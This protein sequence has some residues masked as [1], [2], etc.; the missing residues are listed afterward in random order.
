MYVHIL[1][2]LV[3]AISDNKNLLQ[4]KINIITEAIYR[5]K[6]KHKNRN[7]WNYLLLGIV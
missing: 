7:F 6:E 1:Q 3:G 5:I 4:I 2:F